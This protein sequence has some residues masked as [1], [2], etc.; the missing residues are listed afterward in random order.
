MPKIQLTHAGTTVFFNSSRIAR[1]VDP[2]RKKATHMGPFDTFKD[3]FRTEKKQEALNL[4]YDLLHQPSQNSSINLGMVSTFEKLTELAGE[5]HQDQ[6]TIK[7]DLNRKRIQFLIQGNIIRQQ[8]MDEALKLATLDGHSLCT[9]YINILTEE[10]VKNNRHEQTNTA[11][12]QTTAH[13]NKTTET[14]LVPTDEV[15]DYGIY[16]LNKHKN[17]FQFFKGCGF[18]DA[19]NMNLIYNLFSI[20]PASK[21]AYCI[22]TLFAQMCYIENP[23]IDE[24]NPPIQTRL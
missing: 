21:E 11:E 14:R 2:N 23:P 6:F 8:N 12:T 10:I 9:D 13:R 24:E 1:L 7:Y 22:S 17:I 16:F 20:T 15:M 5:A 3:L 19:N 18:C 4:F